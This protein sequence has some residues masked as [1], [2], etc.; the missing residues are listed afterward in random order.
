M[1][2]D[3]PDSTHIAT[4]AQLD[5][6]IARIARNRTTNMTVKPSISDIIRKN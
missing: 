1:C 2:Q 5:R 3:D 4:L 6:G